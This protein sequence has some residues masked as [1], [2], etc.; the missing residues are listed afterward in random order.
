MSGNTTYRTRLHTMDGWMCRLL[1]SLPFT[2]SWLFDN[3]RRLRAFLIVQNVLIKLVAFELLN[4]DDAHDMGGNGED[5]SDEEDRDIY[6]SNDRWGR[7]E[8]FLSTSTGVMHIAVDVKMY[9]LEGRISLG[10]CWHS[11]PGINS[12]NRG[13]SRVWVMG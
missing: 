13:T 1:F 2:A 9:R 6:F 10:L 11:S 3:L 8:I 12:L 5:A 4:V 7:Y